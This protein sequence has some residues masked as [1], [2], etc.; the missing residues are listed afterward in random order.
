MG[1][2]YFTSRLFPQTAFPTFSFPSPIWHTMLRIIFCLPLPLCLSP[3]NST[4]SQNACSLL[5]IL[6]RF[7]FLF[8]SLTQ[9]KSL[10]RGSIHWGGGV[11]LSYC[12]VGKSLRCFLGW[13]L[14]WAV[15]T[16]TEI[17]GQLVWVYIRTDW[18]KASKPLSSILPW[19]PLQFLPAGPFP[20]WMPALASLSDELSLGHVSQISCFLPKLLLLMV[21]ITATDSGLLSASEVS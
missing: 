18:G 14:V 9:P 16:V 20:A 12:P 1:F 19:P 5:P 6:V 15:T 3:W 21:F 8:V 13:L 4:L 11:P 7:F 2:H 17:P 10:E